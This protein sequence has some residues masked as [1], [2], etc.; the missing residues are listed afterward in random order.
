MNNDSLSEM[1]Q[2]LLDGN[3]STVIDKMQGFHNS[4]ILDPTRHELWMHL[5]NDNT[6]T[7]I[8]KKGYN[9]D[10][11]FNEHECFIYACGGDNTTVWDILPPVLCLLEKD[12]IENII[13]DSDY[14]NDNIEDII[15]YVQKYVEAEMPDLLE[16]QLEVYKNDDYGHIYDYLNNIYEKL[17]YD[18][19]G[20]AS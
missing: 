18:L 15:E 7:F 16:E 12:D 4:Y 11:R 13:G 8:C 9:S 20:L 19:D 10:K 14:S 6:I 2:G 1:W 3:E 17:L 5:E